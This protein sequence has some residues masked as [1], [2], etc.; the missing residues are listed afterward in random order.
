[1]GAQ[2]KMNF[3]SVYPVETPADS[4]EQT[5]FSCILLSILHVGKLLKLKLWSLNTYIYYKKKYSFF[6]R[7]IIAFLRN[8]AV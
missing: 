4:L 6:A 7:V 1:M 2:N 5:T 3:V 8:I